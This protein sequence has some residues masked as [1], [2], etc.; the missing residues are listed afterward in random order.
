MD[1]ENYASE[2]TI[3]PGELARLEERMRIYNS[4]KKKYG[5]EVEDIIKYCDEI[6]IKIELAANF[7]EQINSLKSQIKIA[8][9]NFIRLAIQLRNKRKLA[10]VKLSSCIAEELKELEFL[11]SEFEITIKE[12]NPSSKGMDKIE[13][14]FSPNK[15]EELKLLRDIASSGEISRVMLAVKSILARVDAIPILIFDE[16]DANIGGITASKIAKKLHQLGSDRQLFC[17]THLP[18]V[19]AAGHYHFQVNKVE[20]EGRSI[21]TITQLSDNNKINEIGR[22]LGGSESSSLVYEHAKELTSSILK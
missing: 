14:R 18:Q 19:A 2:I 10:A 11:N 9:E 1:I 20:H 5:P 22:M 12:S 8:E 15:G 13:F 4:L 17:V 3:D 16:I 6:S 7:K 21:S